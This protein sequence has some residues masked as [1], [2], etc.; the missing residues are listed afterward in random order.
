[1]EYRNIG[2]TGLKSSIIGLGCEYLE[3]GKPTYE[4]LKATMDTALDAGVN[5]LDVFM[6]GTEIRETLAKALGNRRK[7][8]M[9]QGHIGSVNLNKQFDISRDL[10]TIQKY[11]E[12]LLRIYGHI[13]LGLMYF[14]TIP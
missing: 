4:E 3:V 6:P 1:M 10:K 12:E 14:G 8:V 9:I 11:F 7:D 5:I 2:S 13:E